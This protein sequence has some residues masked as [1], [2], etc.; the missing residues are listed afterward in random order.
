M[1]QYEK[2]V[3][4]CCNLVA[5]LQL[6]ERGEMKETFYSIKKRKYTLPSYAIAAARRFKCDLGLFVELLEFNEDRSPW[7]SV[8]KNLLQ[9]GNYHSLS[10]FLS[11]INF[12]SHQQPTGF[13]N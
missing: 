1:Q 12:F 4:C 5:Y 10:Y 11:F 6:S 7:E 2:T 3:F 9:P 8:E 13:R